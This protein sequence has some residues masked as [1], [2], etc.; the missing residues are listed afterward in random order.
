MGLVISILT[1][2]VAISDP[3]T[4]LDQG[5]IAGMYMG[6]EHGIR[7]GPDFVFTYGPLGFLNFA[8]DWYVGLANLAYVWLAALHV[9]LSC[10]LVAALRRSLGMIAAI[11]ISFAVLCVL[12]AVEV[13]FAIGALACFF[14][15]RLDRP[16]FAVDALVFGG[17]AFAA[18]ETLVK[19]SVGPVLFLMF[20]VA[21]LAARARPW[22]IG[23]Y[24][25]TFA[26][27]FVGLWLASGQALGDLPDFVSNG[28]Q[29]VSGYSEAMSTSEGSSSATP[30][31]SSARLRSWSASSPSRRWPAT[32]T[33]S[34]A[35]VASSS[36]RSWVSR[37][38]RREWSAS[39]SR[40]WAP[41]PPPS[42]WSGRRCR[43][44]ARSGLFR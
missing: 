15:L 27:T 9:A 37:S 21:L 16:R 22:Q 28:R 24:L 14:A 43:G 12:P 3:D 17:A 8:T 29:I 32:G 10:L 35:G 30:P 23:A 40:T 5:W 4:G 26:G 31:G 42:R 1:W 6:I 33:A 13:P 44:R 41:T 34:P 25:L 7:F 2:F 11:V 19:L 18:T 20:A 39:T 38:S 36:P